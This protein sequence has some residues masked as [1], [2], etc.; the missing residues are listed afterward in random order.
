MGQA[1]TGCNVSVAATE[2]L[3]LRALSYKAA[4]SIRGT[5]YLSN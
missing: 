5:K 4:F 2:M 1:T 3:P